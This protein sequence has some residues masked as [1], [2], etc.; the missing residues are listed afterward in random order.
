MILLSS[1]AEI[2]PQMVYS[3]GLCVLIINL[4]NSIVNLTF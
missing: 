2:N 3:I 1:Q 4:F